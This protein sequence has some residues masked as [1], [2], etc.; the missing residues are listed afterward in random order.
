MGNTDN[1][2][3]DNGKEVFQSRI[4]ECELFYKALGKF[5]LGNT[6]AYDV[7]FNEGTDARFCKEYQIF[8]KY[9]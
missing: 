5:K 7:A 9:S 4:H 2:F 1:C 8:Q 3:L 6:E